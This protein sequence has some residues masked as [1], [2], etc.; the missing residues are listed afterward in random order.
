MTA[1]I[2]GYRVLDHNVMC[3]GNYLINLKKNKIFIFYSVFSF[4][5]LNMVNPVAEPCRVL[6]R[7]SL[8]KMSSFQ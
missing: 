3:N 7:A 2:C 1:G 8:R 6:T 4:I 5:F